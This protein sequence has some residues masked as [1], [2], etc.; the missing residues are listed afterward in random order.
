METIR[1]AR[2][3][4]CEFVARGICMALHMMPE[5]PMLKGIAKICQRTDVL[6]SYRHAMI[7][8]E[9]DTPVGLCLCYD[10][11][12]YHEMR[13]I[14]FPLFEA[15][16]GHEPSH[17][18]MDLEHAED[19]AVAGEYY[20]DSLAVMPQWRKRGIGFRLMQAQLE[21]AKALGF[22]KATLL[23]DPDNEEAQRIYRK[24]GFVEDSQVYAFGQIFWKWAHSLA[25]KQGN[26]PQQAVKEQK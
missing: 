5:E 3:E 24:L 22:H 2:I 25:T 21:R 7:A 18:E 17:E 8:W 9:G 1:D 10:G 14:T 15:L 16:M 23:V 19:E 20:M 6:Y 26:E 11:G 12:K 13:Q 4:D